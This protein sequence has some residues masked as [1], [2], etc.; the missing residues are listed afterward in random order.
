MYYYV[1][2]TWKEEAYKAYSTYQA[3][4]TYEPLPA[5]TLWDSYPNKRPLSGEN[6]NGLRR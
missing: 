3:E 1:L 6:P 5:T 2:Y 4:R